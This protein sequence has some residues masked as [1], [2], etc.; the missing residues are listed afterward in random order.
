MSKKLSEEAAAFIQQ[1]KRQ[2]AKSKEQVSLETKL[3]RELED[4]ETVTGD[5]VGFKAGVD[6]R[7]LTCRKCGHRVGYDVTPTD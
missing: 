2:A 1:T 5:G 6:Y 3:G 4:F 7:L